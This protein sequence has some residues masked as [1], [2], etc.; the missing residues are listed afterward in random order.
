MWFNC[1]L[2]FFRTEFHP[3]DQTAEIVIS[4][5]RRDEQRVAPS[6]NTTYFCADVSLNA[7][8]SCGQIKS[9]RAIESVAVE[10][11]H[12]GHAICGACMNQALGHGRSLQKTESRAGVKFDVHQSYTPRTDHFSFRKS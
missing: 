10:Q 9:G 5:R 11:S 1:T 6:A 2:P 8:L 3:C 12:R 7:R 4:V